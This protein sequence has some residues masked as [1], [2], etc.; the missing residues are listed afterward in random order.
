MTSEEQAREAVMVILAEQADHEWGRDDLTTADRIIA[1]LREM[2]WADQ[3]QRD[4][5]AESSHQ[6]GYKYGQMSMEAERDA[7]RAQMERLTSDEAVEAAQKAHDENWEF[8]DPVKAAI[9]AA[10]AAAKGEG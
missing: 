4:E 10:V 9:T 3:E 6:S 5:D 7:L 2:G 1:K 8:G